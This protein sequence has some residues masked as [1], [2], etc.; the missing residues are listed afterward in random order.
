MHVVSHRGCSG[1]ENHTLRVHWNA[2]LVHAPRRFVLRVFAVSEAAGRSQSEGRGG[3]WPLAMEYAVTVRK[4]AL[5]QA[6]FADG[7]GV[8]S[9]GKQAFPVCT[10]SELLVYP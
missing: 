1:G 3:G 8:G 7:H 2:H 9:Y 6:P 5:V 4:A 10:P